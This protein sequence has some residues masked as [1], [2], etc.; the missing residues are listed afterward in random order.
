MATNK[1]EY[2]LY[3]NDKDGS[4]VTVMPGED[5]PSWAKVTN[6]YVLG[7]DSE[8]PGSGESEEVESSGP[9]PRAGKGSGEAAWRAYAEEQGVDVSGAE[10]R[11]DIIDA[12]DAAGV[13]VE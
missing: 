3:L 9:P 8:E 7:K 11:D 4:L 5:I 1:S 12:L 10:G 6:P 2:A 13:P